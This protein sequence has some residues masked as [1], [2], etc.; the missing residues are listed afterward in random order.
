MSNWK[1][2]KLEKDIRLFKY[3]NIEIAYKYYNKKINQKSILF[4]YG[5]GANILMADQ[6]APFLAGH[7]YTVLTIDY[8]GHGYSPKIK[9]NSVELN[10]KLLIELLKYLNEKRIILI[11][12]SFGGILALDFYKEF[13]M[14]ID[15]FVLIHSS[16]YFKKSLYK[17]I[18][19]VNGCLEEQFPKNKD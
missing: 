10:T 3:K 12:Y 14:N 4:L 2:L 7:D 11:G 8:P 9:N 13:Y 1:P 19:S 6:F 15:K 17:K 18:I 16:Y 5:F